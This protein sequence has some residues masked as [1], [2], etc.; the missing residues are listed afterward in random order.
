MLLAG[1]IGGTKTAVALFSTETD[2]L[3]PV[4]EMTF[5]NRNYDSLEA[6]IYDFMRDNPKAI[7]SASFG[8]AG[9][10]SMVLGNL[11]PRLFPLI[12]IDG[13]LT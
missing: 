9:L 10:D 4:V 2:T 12:A 5:Q 13:S 3:Q 11:S 7:T 6:V 8:V 1:D